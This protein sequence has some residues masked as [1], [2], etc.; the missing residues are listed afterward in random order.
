VAAVFAGLQPSS[1]HRRT[2]ADRATH[3]ITVARLGR[4]P[5]VAVPERFEASC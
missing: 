5:F 3:L 2:G 4:S 1:P